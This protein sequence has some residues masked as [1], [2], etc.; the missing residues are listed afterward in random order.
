MLIETFS[1][2]KAKG[3]LL[4]GLQEKL[5][6]CGVQFAPISHEGVFTQLQELGKVD[7]F[8]LLVAT[9][10]NHYK[11]NDH[12]EGTIRE[13]ISEKG[14]T[15]RDALRLEKF[16]QLFEHILR[17]YDEH[18]KKTKKIDFHDMINKATKYV[19]QGRY[20]SPYFFILVDEFQDIS[21]ARARLIQA[22]AKQRPTNVLF[23][24]GDDWQAIY[25][26]AG[27]DISIMRNFRNHF[28][29]TQTLY[30]DQ[31]F[32]FTK[33][34]EEVSTKFILRNPSQIPKKISTQ[35]DTAVPCIFIGRPIDEEHDLVE[36]SL[37]QISK[38]VNGQRKH[39]L[40]LGRYKHSEPKNLRALPKQFP[41]LSIKFLTVHKAKGLEAD[42]VIVVGL[43]VGK[44]GFPTEIT[45]DPII[46][47]VLA[48][49][50][51]HTHAEER[52]LFYV[53]MTRAREAVYLLADSGAPSCFVTELESNGYKVEFFGA[54]PEISFSCMSCKTGRLVRR[55]GRSGPF[56]GCSNYP[57]CTYTR[58][59]TPSI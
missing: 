21:I 45:D 46:D 22:L 39:V 4:P 56:Y 58:N 19:A 15:Y 11:S 20:T 49:R 47:L 12:K 33:H 5:K 26:F 34:I 14:T 44:Y 53:A 8:S 30:L 35:R 50:E 25:R 31:T 48:E 16:L 40:I 3:T 51:D 23:C 43:Q 13:K 29:Y 37:K 10:L 57:Y 7:L 38:Q 9:F 42:F 18:L 2:E 36:D 1:Y 59:A 32:R 54:T 28:G 27:C 6:K 24:V 17:A 41:K 52:R 55:E